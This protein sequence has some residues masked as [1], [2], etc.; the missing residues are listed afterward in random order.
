MPLLASLRPSVQ[1]SVFQ[2]GTTREPLKRFSQNF[3]WGSCSNIFRFIPVFLQ[4][5]ES[6][7]GQFPWR[8]SRVFARKWLGGQYLAGE[9]P[10]IQKGRSQILKNAPELS[11]QTFI[12]ELV[13]F[14]FLQAI[15]IITKF[16]WANSTY[17]TSLLVAFRY[18]SRR[19]P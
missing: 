3:I 13:C 7:N 16:I 10:A 12:F 9:F 1:M 15:T 8:P 17:S 14:D 4:K 6:N 2:C 5:S 19:M 18:I 11:R